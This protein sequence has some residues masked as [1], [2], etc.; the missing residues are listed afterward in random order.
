MIVI[1]T[2]T[3]LIGHQVL[4]RVLEADEPVRVIARDP[5]RLPAQARERVEVIEGS[6][7][8]PEVVDRA[9]TGAD[10][11]FWLAPPNRTAPNL[12]AVYAGFAR[13]AGEA[14]IRHRV[15][16]VVDVSALG[17]GVTEHAG[18]VSAS[19]AM[20]D[21]FASTGSSFRALL[22]PSFMDNVL[23]QADPIK[24][25]GMFFS[26]VSPDRKL[27][28]CATRDIAAVAAGL[29]LD[30]SWRGQDTVAVLG[31]EDLSHNE[32]AEIIADVLGTPVSYR[33]VP[34]DA[35]RQQLAGV[36]MSDAMAE[37]MIDMMVAKDQ[38]LDN[39]EPRTPASTTP[40][41]FRQW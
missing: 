16:R 6:H 11:V 1:T 31:P 8:D 13:P 39:A 3:G 38:G 29:L 22:M 32:M 7:G 4:D 20:D 34:I 12:D 25:Q 18:L 9:F 33:Q 15:T 17:R 30:H 40:T 27:P 28:T 26:T 2:P 37:G 36:G 35:F 23:R 21:P 41:S 10:S 19:L 14:I 5:S 24:R